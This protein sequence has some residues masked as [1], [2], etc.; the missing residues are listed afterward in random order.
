MIILIYLIVG[1][2]T[3]G[4]LIYMSKNWG[5]EYE[6]IKTHLFDDTKDRVYAFNSSKKR[7]TAIVHRKLDGSVRLYCKGASEY[8]LRDCTMYMDTTGRP[9][10]MTPSKKTELEN[11]INFMA[12]QALRTLL[13]AHKDYPNA[14][15]LPSDWQDNPPDHSKSLKPILSLLLFEYNTIKSCR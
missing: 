7:S 5:Y 11:H 13:L 1:N 6:E 15:A 3:E 9:Q 14:A 12:D 4:A 2:K 8:V 10:P